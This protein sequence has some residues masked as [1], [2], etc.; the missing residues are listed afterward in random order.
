MPPTLMPR[1]IVERAHRAGIKVGGMVGSVQ[2]A[3]RQREAGVD[4]VIAQ[5][6]EA[7]GHTGEIATMVLTPQVVDAVASIPVLAAGGIATGRQFAAALA[8]GAEGAWCGSVWL[9]TAQSDLLPE[10]KRRLLAAASSDTAR[11]RSYTGK[12]ARFLKN[13]WTE[14]WDAP[15]A[16]PPLMRPLQHLLSKPAQH[17]IE[18]ARIENLLGTPVGQV[19]GQLNQELSVR[20][21]YAEMMTEFTDAFERF[22]SIARSD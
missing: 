15:D 11:T 1:D 18:R 21:V 22:N 16:P 20:Q 7:G 17:R 6:H 9:T 3:I 13:A 2:H 10:T 4:L 5:G 12:P 19:V 14:A 8:L